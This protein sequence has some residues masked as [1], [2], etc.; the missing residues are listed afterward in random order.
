VPVAVP[1]PV[2]LVAASSP[3]PASVAGVA[4]ATKA[5]IRQM[6]AVERKA[7]VAPAA[8]SPAEE[9]VRTVAELPDD[10]RRQLPALAVAGATYSE[11]PASRMLLINGQLYHE[12]DK[13][14]PELTL[15]QIQLRRAVLSFRGYRYSVSY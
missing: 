11:S 2:P 13:L 1:N 12:G 8:V 7:G 9:R 14:A 10:I 6:D 3:V 15:Q 4:R 5:P